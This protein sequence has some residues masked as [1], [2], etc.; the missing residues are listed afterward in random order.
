MFAVARLQLSERPHTVVPVAA[1]KR[2]ETEARVFVVGPTK[3]VQERLVQLGET[4]GDVVAV[5]GGVKTGESVVLQPSPDV[6]DGAHV[7]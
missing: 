4:K 2:D 5:L 6:R 3:E 7:E 1:L